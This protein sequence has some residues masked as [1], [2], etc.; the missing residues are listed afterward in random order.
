M[1]TRVLIVEDE[2]NLGI[3]LN[4]YLLGQGYFCELATSLCEARDKFDN[5]QVVLMDVGLP[6]GSGIDLAK[7]FLSQKKDLTILFLSAQND[8]EIRVQGL[9][10]GAV[11]YIT[12]PFALKE[13]MLRLSRI[14]PV[15]KN[16]DITLKG[17]TLCFSTY[18]IV[19]QNQNVFPLSP[20]ERDLLKLLWDNRNEA[21]S[22]ELIL[23]RLW[24]KNLEASHR[25]IDN[26][27]VKL[28]K[29]FDNS[30]SLIRIKS[31]RAVGYLLEY[32]EI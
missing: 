30:S 23:E 6:D 9:E 5:P 10:T 3:T 26:Y 24:P 4:E 29:I 18:K 13:L 22:R 19:D 32:T 15:K 12:K 21:I 28:R 27:I 14:S 8:P 17:I 7:E 16:D 11:D 25:T 20:K 31:I 2:K 1:S